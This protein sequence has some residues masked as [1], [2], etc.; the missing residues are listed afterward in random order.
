MVCELLFDRVKKPFKALGLGRRERLT[1]S[2]GSCNSVTVAEVGVV[3]KNNDLG[4]AGEAGTVGRME[5]GRGNSLM[6]SE[7]SSER[8]D[9]KSEREESRLL[10]IF[11]G[12]K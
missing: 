3:V 1:A 12:D 7:V 8:T 5:G 6:R 10:L 9:V 4:V 11:C 2:M